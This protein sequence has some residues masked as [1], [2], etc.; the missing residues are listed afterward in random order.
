MQ[1]LTQQLQS[2][3]QQLSTVIEQEGRLTP[4]RAAA[5]V[6]EANISEEAVNGVWKITGL[7]LLDEKRI[8]PY[9]FQNK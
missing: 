1:A 4:L 6:K 9:A 7:E 2:L 8:D 3:I 5:I